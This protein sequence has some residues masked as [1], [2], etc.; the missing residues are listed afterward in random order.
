MALHPLDF[1]HMALL[2]FGKSLIEREE[3][4]EQL[5]DVSTSLVLGFNHSSNFA[6]KSIRV[7]FNRTS[8]FFAI[9]GRCVLYKCEELTED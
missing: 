6:K 3:L 8:F 2:F 1:T 9:L 7:W 5:I 4:S